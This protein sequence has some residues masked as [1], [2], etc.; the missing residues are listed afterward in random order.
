MDITITEAAQNQI[1]QIIKTDSLEGQNLRIGIKGQGCSGFGYDLYFESSEPSNLDEI[2]K[3]SDITIVID[4]ISF[5][6]LI[7][8]EIDYIDSILEAGFKFKNPNM[9]SSCGCG[10][11]FSI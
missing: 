9:K 5:Q 6:Y 10:K 4:P 8:T 3:I 11:S 7:G 2:I 1:R